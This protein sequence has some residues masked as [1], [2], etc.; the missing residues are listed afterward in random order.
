VTSSSVR[1]PSTVVDEKTEE[2]VALYVAFTLTDCP[3]N[4]PNFA[5]TGGLCDARVNTALHEQ[6]REDVFN[7]SD[8]L[9]LVHRS[10]A[11]QVLHNNGYL[12]NVMGY[13][14]IVSPTGFDTT[15][16]M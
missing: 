11:I 13:P 10:N 16:I 1:L 4:S 12:I 15:L 9:L 3:L 6:G 2:K 5:Y 8:R 14:D 7:Y